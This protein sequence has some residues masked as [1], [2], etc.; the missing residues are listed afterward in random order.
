M[1]MQYEIAKMVTGNQISDEEIDKELASLSKE[2][3]HE[4]CILL[5]KMMKEHIEN[6]KDKPAE[7][8]MLQD[9]I[10][11]GVANNVSEATLW[12]AYLK[13]M[14]VEYSSR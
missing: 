1:N 5:D 4:Q 14:E 7:E 3:W 12:I 10:N 2:E 11:V 9:L 13:W 6:R 8:I